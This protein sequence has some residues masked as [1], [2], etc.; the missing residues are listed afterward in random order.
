MNVKRIFQQEIEVPENIH[1]HLRNML[2][3]QVALRNFVM[4]LLPKQPDIPFREVK[5]KVREY[6]KDNELTVSSTSP[7]FNELY[8]RYKKFMQDNSYVYKEGKDIQY[9]SYKVA[10]WHNY[11]FS[12]K[13]TEMTLRGLN[14]VIKL[15]Y[16]LPEII[17]DGKMFYVNI[18]YYAKENRY[19]LSI[20]H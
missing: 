3:V 7:I 16:E 10:R 11:H 4:K 8:Y 13:G 12:I 20:F 5:A 2:A 14:G 19:Q 15:P 17:E 9:I 6:I 18:G 1:Q